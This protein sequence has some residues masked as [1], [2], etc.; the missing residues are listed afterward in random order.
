MDAKEEMI[1][2]AYQRLLSLKIETVPD[3]KR[4]WKME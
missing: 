4:K 2:T 3:L 1:P